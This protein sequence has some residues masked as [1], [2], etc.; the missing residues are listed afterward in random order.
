MVPGFRC[1]RTAASGAAELH[2]VFERIR[3]TPEVFKFRAFTRLAQLQYLLATGQM[4]DNFFMR[5]EQA[6]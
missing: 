4:D 5:A 6:A 2:D 3:M 1:R